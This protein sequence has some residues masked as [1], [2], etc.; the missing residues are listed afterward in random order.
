MPLR[1]KIMVP[2]TGAR[3]NSS[4]SSDAEIWKPV[5]GDEPEDVVFT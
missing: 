3:L 1:A 2:E 5:P 4:L